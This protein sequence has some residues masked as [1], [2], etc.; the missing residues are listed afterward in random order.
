LQISQIE[1]NRSP[2]DLDIY[3]DRNDMDDVFNALREFATD[4]P[5]LNHTA[6]YASVL[7]HFLM[8][9][10]PVELVGG[11]K[12][13]TMDSKYEVEAA[14][15]HEAH[16]I[17][18]HI[19]NN[20]LFLM[21]LAHELLFNILRDRPDRYEPIALSMLQMPELHM[22]ALQALLARH[23]WGEGLL[24]KLVQLLKVI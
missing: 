13:T 12:V 11:F 22:P 10:I 6:I 24:N 19:G 21:P 1:I 7:S 20:E 16:A 23:H 5:E 2:R 15:L 8:A 3:V 18:A 14:Y 9:G 17:H 4:E